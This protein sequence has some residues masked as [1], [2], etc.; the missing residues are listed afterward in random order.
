MADDTGYEAV[1]PADA[2][3]ES[4]ILLA[5]KGLRRRSCIEDRIMIVAIYKQCTAAAFFLLEIVRIRKNNNTVVIGLFVFIMMKHE[6][7]VMKK[8]HEEKPPRHHSREEGRAAVIHLGIECMLLVRIDGICCFGA[9]L[10]NAQLGLK[11]LATW[12]FKEAKT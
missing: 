12:Y 11:V 3:H 10:Q 9:L 7:F 1:V 5:A 6:R 2:S 8:I 4:V